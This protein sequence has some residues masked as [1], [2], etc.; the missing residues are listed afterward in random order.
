MWDRRPII[1]PPDS[2]PCLPTAHIL[3][4]LTSRH[5][6]SFHHTPKVALLIPHPC[7][8]YVPVTCS[9][10]NITPSEL[11]PT[12]H[13]SHATHHSFFIYVTA[14]L[15]KCC[16]ISSQPALFSTNQLFP[17]ETRFFV[18]ICSSTM[19]WWYMSCVHYLLIVIHSKNI[20][21]VCLRY[22]PLCKTLS[23]IESNA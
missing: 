23:W 13:P 6:H 21:Y 14:T 19:T 7:F 5:P 2:S 12:P 8:T 22:K 16:D 15:N 20:G 10:P 4:Y 17:W 1:T 18:N 9:S 3:H 11:F